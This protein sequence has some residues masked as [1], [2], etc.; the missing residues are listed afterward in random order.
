MEREKYKKF[1]DLEVW[2]EGCRLSVDIYKT[3]ETIKDFGFK[4]Q[5]QRASISIPSNIAEGYERGITAEFIRFLYIAKGSAG[6]LRTQLYIAKELNYIN[7][8][9]MNGLIEKVKIIS[10]KI[11]KLISKLKEKRIKT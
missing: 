4:D 2:K 6:E 11:Q 8:E 9:T 3:F 5:I 10:A 1:E 7:Q